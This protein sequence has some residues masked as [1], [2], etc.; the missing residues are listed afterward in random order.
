M[1]MRYR[2][3]IF[4]GRKWFFGFSPKPVPPDERLKGR[5]SGM[6]SIILKRKM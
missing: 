6:N 4:L 2:S 3:A 1:G 5:G